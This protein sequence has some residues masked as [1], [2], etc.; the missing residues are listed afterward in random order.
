MTAKEARD[1][2]VEALMSAEVEDELDRLYNDIASAAKAGETMIGND[3]LSDAAYDILV[4]M[5]YTIHYGVL[6]P[7][8]CQI[9]W[10]TPKN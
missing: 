6:N 1:L 7:N 3:T 9:T 8:L 4:A 2:T 5:G 10:H